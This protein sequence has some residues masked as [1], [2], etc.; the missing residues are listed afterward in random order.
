[1]AMAFQQVYR[2]QTAG[3]RDGQT[4]RGFVTLSASGTYNGNTHAY[5][6]CRFFFLSLAC[7]SPRNKAVE[8]MQTAGKLRNELP[9]GCLEPASW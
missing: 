9:P 8:W 5:R 3:T 6:S 1:M 7:T 4:G 2:D